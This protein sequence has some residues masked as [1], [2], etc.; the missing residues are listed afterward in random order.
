LVEIAREFKI[1]KYSSVS[2]IIERVKRPIG[3]DRKLQKRI[4]EIEA[5]IVKSQE[6]T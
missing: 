1:N 6:Q 3:S 2:S 4:K 5:Q